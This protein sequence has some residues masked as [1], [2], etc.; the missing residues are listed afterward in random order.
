M[1]NALEI[2][3]EINDE[4]SETIH[5]WFS[6]IRFSETYGG[7]SKEIPGEISYAIAEGNALMNPMRAYQ[8]NS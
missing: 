1:K 8:N 2:D 4:I 7:T 5:A 3:G 6:Y